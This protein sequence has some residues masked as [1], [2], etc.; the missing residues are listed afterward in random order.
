M[1]FLLE[2][3]M[4]RIWQD[5]WKQ[6]Q[7]LVKKLTEQNDLSI[8]ENHDRRGYKDY[9]LDHI[10]PIQQGFYMNINPHLISSL[11]NLQFIPHVDNMRKSIQLTGKSIKLLNKWGIDIQQRKSEWSMSWKDIRYLQSKTLNILNERQLSN[12]VLQKENEMLQKENEMLQKENERLR[13][14]VDLMKEG[15][16]QHRVNVNKRRYTTH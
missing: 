16:Y 1:G 4:K 3:T 7:R 8:L 12:Q 9:H 11:E 13:K 15:Y 2:H 10:V 14:L 6:Y 5:E